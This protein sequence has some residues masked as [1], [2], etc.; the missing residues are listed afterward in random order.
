MSL[1][2][3]LYIVIG[4][5]IVVGSPDDGF[6]TKDDCSTTNLSKSSNIARKFSDFKNL[7]PLNDKIYLIKETEMPQIL[8][9]Y[10]DSIY[11]H[12]YEN[13]IKCKLGSCSVT[14]DRKQLKNSL[15]RGI[16][17]YGTSFDARDLPL[18]RLPHH[19]WALFHEESPKNK[20]MYSTKLGISL[21]NHT[22]TFK[23][24]SDYPL[25][26]QCL[27]DTDEW[28]DKKFFVETKE[29]N[30][31]QKEL[32]LAPV[33]YFQ[34]D[35]DPPSDRDTYVKELMK[36]IAIDSY[37]PCLNNK[38]PPDEINGFHHLSSDS[39]YHFLARYKFQLAFENCLCQDY[40]TEK[41]FRPLHIGSVPVY[42][43]SP[44]A[45]EFMPSEKAV[46]M[47]E[48]FDSP[49]KL[50]EYLKKL[51]ANDESYDEY[52]KHRYTGKFS[53]PKLEISL[54]LQKW[55]LPNKYQKPNFG[56]FMFSGFSCH[57]CDKLHERNDLLRKHLENPANRILPPRVASHDHM[58]CPEPRP[59]LA[60]SKRNTYGKLAFEDGQK[61]AEALLQMIRENETDS[62]IYSSKYLK[63]KTQSYF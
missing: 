38:K 62:T 54:K 49:R 10:S 48:D 45:E 37:G 56:Y 26:T 61:E 32:G 35:C 19:E 59:I 3:K 55:S 40:M 15:T 27:K 25:S 20:W 2:A 29:K 43:G 12:S 4:I 51:N 13:Q 6:C 22:A 42:L 18:P 24:E 46:I 60:N 41:L 39:Y 57:V 1:F 44:L 9:W 28:L 63:I 50:A 30:R 5:V 33:V 17:F 14:K 7:P 16:I 21:F 36:Y 31:L 23:R 47:V 53:N 58:G 11:P 34:R 52:L 8:W